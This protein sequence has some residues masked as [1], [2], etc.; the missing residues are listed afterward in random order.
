MA[1]RKLDA[2]T[3]AQQ[4]RKKR[5]WITFVR[6]VRYGVNNF[7]RNAWLT[8]A[9][10]AVMTITL[11]I[12][13]MTFV[14]QSVLGDTVSNLRDNVDM[15][16]YLKTSTKPEDAKKIVDDIRKLP[17]VTRVGYISSE[18]ARKDFAATNTDNKS[19]L[20]ALNQATNSF[21]A[22]IRV[23]VENI[24]DPAE[25]KRYVD[26]SK[27][28][29]QSLDPNREP[30][31]SGDRK[32]AIATIGRWIEFAQRFGAVASIIFI[33]ISS[34]IIFNTIRMAIFNRRDEIQMMKLIG[35][36]RNFIRGPFVVEAIVYGFLAAVIA[37]S[38]GLAIL[39]GIRAPLE[40]AVPAIGGVVSMVTMYVGFVLLVMIAIGALIGIISSLLATRRYLKI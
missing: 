35:A 22:V 36:D 32:Q 7:S 10:T 21:P 15:S 17:S 3:F 2:K 37:T 1:K 11:L 20:E 18:Q 12:M 13:F 5:Q 25:L 23:N 30:S 29:Q 40:A 24:N 9:A 8:V 6:M 34:L 14:A 38:L 31:Y 33:A 39:Y 4:K 16:I 27:L 26:S 19:A 28:V